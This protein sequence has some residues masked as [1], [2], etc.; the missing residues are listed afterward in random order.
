MRC[1]EW[2]LVALAAGFLERDEREAVLGD[3]AEAGEGWWHGLLGVLGL[4]V[5]RQFDLWQNWRPW[6]AA[7]GL[8]FPFSL[9]LMGIS[10]SIAWTCSHFGASRILV[11]SAPS[12]G[13]WLLSLLCQC[14]LLLSCS[15]AGGVVVGSISRPTL[16]VSAALC[17]LPG[18]YCLSEF[19]VRSLPAF[20]L[21]LFLVPALLGVRQGLYRFN[22]RRYSALG[23][24]AV[25]TVSMVYLWS[26]GK[27]WILNWALLW[28]AWYLVAT[29]RKPYSQAA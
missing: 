28:P 4:L 24:A 6:L 21:F 1:G 14:C 20:S 29:A 9:T 13:Y 22:L 15:W 7:F 23:L 8:A 2:R 25:A 3:L 16:W 12:A 26:C 19:H 18:I 10:V 11:G 27:F 17:L 5:R